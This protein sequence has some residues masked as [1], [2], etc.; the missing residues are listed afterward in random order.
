MS[1]FGDDSEGAKGL[2][3][4]VECNDYEFPFADFWDW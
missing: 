1:L 4:A 3:A 2:M